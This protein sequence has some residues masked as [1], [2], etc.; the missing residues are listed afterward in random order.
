MISHNESRYG[1]KESHRISKDTINEEEK[2][3][4]SKDDIGK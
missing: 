3:D 1:S 2:K 4:F